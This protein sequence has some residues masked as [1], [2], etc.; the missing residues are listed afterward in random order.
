MVKVSQDINLIKWTFPWQSTDHQGSTW[1]TCHFDSV[2]NKVTDWWDGSAVWLLGSHVKPLLSLWRRGEWAVPLT[3]NGITP[4]SRR[5]SGAWLPGSVTAGTTEDPRGSPLGVRRWGLLITITQQPPPRLHHTLTFPTV[6]DLPHTPVCTWFKKPSTSSDGSHG[7]VNGVLD[8]SD[9]CR[10]RGM[11]QPASATINKDRTA[12]CQRGPSWKQTS[13][14]E[15]QGRALAPADRR[16]RQGR[17]C[18]LQVIS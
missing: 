8:P 17:A 10:N 14:W 13:V 5:P 3:V 4:T 11:A 15:R 12:A 2:S 18:A 1:S 6:I 9:V 16:G 7:G